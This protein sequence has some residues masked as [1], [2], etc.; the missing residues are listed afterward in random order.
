MDQAVFFTSGTTASLRGSHALRRLDSYRLI[1]LAHARASLLGGHE[2]ARV[3]ALSPPP[4]EPVASSLSCMMGFFMDAFDDARR[5]L[6]EANGVDLGALR[7]ESE[8]AAAQALPLLLLGTA[9]ACAQLLQALRDT[10]LAL[11][12]GSRVMLTGGFKGGSAVYKHMQLKQA[13]AAALKLDPKAIVGEYGMTEL[14]SQ[15]Y[16]NL[17]APVSEHL[18]YYKPP[19]WLRVTPV[20]ALTQNPVARGDAGLARFIDIGNVDSAVAVLTLDLVRETEHGIEL[21]GRRQG[22][23]LRGCSLGTELLIA[24]AEQ[25][26]A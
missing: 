26:R 22:A 6:W 16:E 18:G 3:A 5:W 4:E 20:D 9:S 19:P 7:Q 23:P 17:E 12:K 2:R 8:R 21:L 1:A 13:L 11:P 15:L 24:G 10:R 25:V 14:T